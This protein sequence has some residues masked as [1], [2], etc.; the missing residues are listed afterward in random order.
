M[1]ETLWDAPNQQVVRA[2]ESAPWEEGTGGEAV[3]PK[4]GPLDSMTKDQLLVYADDH[5]ISADST[6][7][8]AEIKA[9]IE[10]G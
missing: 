6:M 5:E 4:Q 7:T 8:K 10:A 1:T 3:E 9:A 2:D